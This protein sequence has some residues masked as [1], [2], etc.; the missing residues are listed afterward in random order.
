MSWI[1]LFTGVLAV[2]AWAAILVLVAARMIAAIP[3][4]GVRRWT[5]ILIAMVAGFLL[6]LYLVAVVFFS[7]LFLQD[8]TRLLTEVYAGLPTTTILSIGL[9]GTFSVAFLGLTVY[10]FLPRRDEPY[11]PRAA[12][13]NGRRLGRMLLVSIVIFFLAL[14]VQDFELRWRLRRMEARALALAQSMA[15]AAVADD[16]NA[17]ILYQQIMDS[18]EDLDELSDAEKRGPH[19][20]RA[21]RLRQRAA[22]GIFRQAGCPTRRIAKSS[23]S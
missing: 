13:W 22:Q 16:A 21:L 20:I 11:L 2:V 1:V 4:A 19:R 6:S 7:P 3:R 10:G 23:R 8:L 15:P 17:A 5:V 14:V 18:P 9:V 12:A